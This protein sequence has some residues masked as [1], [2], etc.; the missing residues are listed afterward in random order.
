M[1]DAAT[2]FDSAQYR[3]VFGHLPTGV[4]VITGRSANGEPLGLTIGSFTS[5]SLDPPLA[6]FFVGRT[7]RSWPLIATRGVFTAN[8]LSA[9][10]SEVCWRFAKD[11][12]DGSRFSGIDCSSS[13]NGSPVLP[14]VVAT[15]DCTLQDSHMVGDHD[16]VVGAVTDVRVLN[17]ALPAMVFFKGKTGD[18]RIES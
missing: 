16:L 10:Q 17:A 18:A 12:T 14:D 2:S 15:I 3:S 13:L 8:V 4:V 7:S 11:A 1:S 6:G 5:I 9:A